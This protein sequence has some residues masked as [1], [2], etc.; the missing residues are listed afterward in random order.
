MN[1]DY[2]ITRFKTHTELNGNTPSTGAVVCYDGQIVERNKDKTE[3]WES[4]FIE[5]SDCHSKARLHRATYDTDRDWL[6]KV[7]TLHQA[8]SEYYEH[9]YKK[10][11]IEH[12]EH[13]LP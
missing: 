9:L 7:K 12:P 6:V 5:I 1:T 3:P 13:K 2:T 11:K 10:Y 4:Q 8:I